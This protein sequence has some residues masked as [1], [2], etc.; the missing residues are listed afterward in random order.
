MIQPTINF[1][2]E[3]LRYLFFHILGGQCKI[4]GGGVSSNIIK[5]IS[6]KLNIIGLSEKVGK[7]IKRSGTKSSVGGV[8]MSSFRAVI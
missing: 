3:L 1:F 2:N 5:G 4:Q 7:M 8:W 6:M